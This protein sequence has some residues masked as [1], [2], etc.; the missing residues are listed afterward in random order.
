[1][2]QKLKEYLKIELNYTKVGMEKAR[3]DVFKMD[4]IAWYARQRGLGAT[5]FA[6]ALGMEFSK[7]EAIFEEYVAELEELKNEMF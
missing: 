2:E 4:E 1:M 6:N 5:Q 3:E 7:A